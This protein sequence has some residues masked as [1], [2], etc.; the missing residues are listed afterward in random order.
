MCAA[1]RQE[2]PLFSRK[3]PT[4]TANTVMLCEV[5]RGW[6]RQAETYVGIGETAPSVLFATARFRGQCLHHHL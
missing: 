3:T 4:T 1:R 6:S 5:G 2:R